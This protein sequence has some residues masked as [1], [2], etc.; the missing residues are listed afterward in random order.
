MGSSCAIGSKVKPKV[1]VSEQSYCID[2]G[3]GPV[4]KFADQNIYYSHPHMAFSVES[5]ERKGKE[6][7]MARTLK[8]GLDRDQEFIR[9]FSKKLKVAK[10]AM[11]DCV[12]HDMN[13]SNKW[14]SVKPII[15]TGK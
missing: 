13:P 3:Q 15:D 10:E 5:L 12:Y 2:K 6:I 14:Y 7:M 11:D 8:Q 9:E 1:A 4:V